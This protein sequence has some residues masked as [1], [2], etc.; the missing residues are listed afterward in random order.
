MDSA[1][2]GPY[3]WLAVVTARDGTQA[4]AGGKMPSTWAWTGVRAHGTPHGTIIL[5]SQKCSRHA[6]GILQDPGMD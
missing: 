2:V 4:Q 1:R 5:S 3:E 6:V